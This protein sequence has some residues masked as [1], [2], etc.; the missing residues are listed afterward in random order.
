[1]YRIFCFSCRNAHEEWEDQERWE[2]EEVDPDDLLSPEA[3][4][5]GKKSPSRDKERAKQPEEEERKTATESADQPAAHSRQSDVDSKS[6]GGTAAA[7][8]TSPTVA[9]PT[10]PEVG[11]SGSKPSTESLLQQQ[12]QHRAAAAAEEERQQQQPKTDHMETMAGHLVSSLVD[13]DEPP[14]SRHHER[15]GGTFSSLT[16]PTGPPPQQHP[17][18]SSSPSWT[19]L[20]PQGQIQ[21]PFQSDEMLEWYTAGYFPVD[22][23]VKRTE[24]TA[25]LSLNEVTKL[26]HGRC[27]FTR[28]PQP[29]P[30]TN[31]DLEEQRLKQEQQQQLLLMHQQY[32]LQQ[33]LL[34][35][36]QQ[37][38]QLLAM[39]Q[40][41]PD[42]SKLLSLGPLRLGGLGPAAAASP[43]ELIG[44][45]GG[46]GVVDPLRSLLGSLGGVTAA[47]E[48]PQQQQQPDP[49]KQF[50]ARAGG[51][52]AQGLDVRNSR[53]VLP[54]L[55]HG[56]PAFEPATGGLF[57]GQQPITDYNHHQQHGILPQNEPPTPEQPA[58]ALTPAPADFDP[59]QSLLQ[60]LQS[61]RTTA[62]SSS[63][64]S[65]QLIQ[66]SGS[67][68]SSTPA[69][70][71]IHTV[72]EQQ[73]PA[74]N[75]HH[76][77]FTE[78]N[79]SSSQYEKPIGKATTASIWDRPA[80]APVESAPSS[81]VWNTGSEP[82]PDRTE[83]TTSSEDRSP[84]PPLPP[85]TD[86]DDPKLAPSA[87]LPAEEVATFV[88]PKV[89]EKKEKRS[90]KAEEKR[91]A[92]EAKKQSEGSSMPYIPGMPGSV[93]P[94]EQVRR[95][96]HIKWAEKSVAD[97][98]CIYP[99]S[100][101]LSIPDLGSWLLSP[102]GI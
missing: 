93:Q 4:K 66:R 41:R 35:Q 56:P 18:P 82:S 37:Q 54:N 25:F 12:Q 8:R 9:Q 59:I 14:A 81:S 67:S 45:Y 17:P 65:P 47:A 62:S 33:Q 10:G 21:G 24:D 64:A 29:P 89:A 75:N 5:N 83:A 94:E 68:S 58:A 48:T 63:S 36:Q 90:K 87:V 46:G 28:G 101:N 72:P 57:G 100:N 96:G 70:Q 26:Y 50:L 1:M 2:D 3:K 88:T 69:S 71:K 13:E 39:Q 6:G 32:L 102:T 79:Q 55:S 27:P 85:N 22:L 42:L 30:F 78:Y 16:P 38:Q 49:L 61:S 11:G 15:L 73:Q 20:D 86:L 77:Y 31:N 43:G 51:A 52:G 60:Q 99:G 23:M 34:A 91:R 74:A 97:S 19:Y 92:K 76:E 98:G 40:Q 44:G 95:R 7:S 53:P 80:A 84:S